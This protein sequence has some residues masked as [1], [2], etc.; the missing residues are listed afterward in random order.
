MK[1]MPG[2]VDRDILNLA[3]EGA[4]LKRLTEDGFELF[5]E[6]GTANHTGG[7]RLR[8][9]KISKP[10][11]Y[12]TRGFRAIR[13]PHPAATMQF[14]FGFL[15]K[16]VG[17]DSKVILILG[18]SDGLQAREQAHRSFGDGTGSKKL[19]LLE[20]TR[21]TFEGLEHE[22]NVASGWHDGFVMNAMLSEPR[23]LSLGD[24]RF[25]LGIVTNDAAPH[26]GT[27]GILPPLMEK[28]FVLQFVQGPLL[29]PWMTG[30]QVR[31]RFRPWIPGRKIQLHT[32]LIQLAKG[33]VEGNSGLGTAHE[34]GD[35]HG[36]GFPILDALRN[37]GTQGAV[38][39]KLQNNVRPVIVEQ[40]LHGQPE[41]NGLADVR[42]PVAAIEP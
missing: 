2:K 7:L 40:C 20:I 15:N 9:G 14:P 29:V 21:S 41:A 30:Q 16:G 1:R 39:R 13:Q 6:L 18:V 33:L 37:G 42:P 5:I 17:R 38:R 22:L 32:G 3:E 25:K 19:D 8:N 36:I 31:Y 26:Q 23:H 12:C 34:R 11:R 24:S 27:V 4:V 10:L 28:F 35:I